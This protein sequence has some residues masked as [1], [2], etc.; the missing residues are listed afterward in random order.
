MTA[1][2]DIKRTES[3]CYDNVL[4]LKTIKIIAW[5][6]GWINDECQINASSETCDFHR[7]KRSQRYIAF[8]FNNDWAF[9]IVIWV[10]YYSTPN[11]GENSFSIFVN[12]TRY[13]WWMS[14]DTTAMRMI[15]DDINHL[16]VQSL[17][18]K[19]SADF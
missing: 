6:Y 2:Q 9:F 8:S 12:M 19:K 7:G 4:F 11:R 17:S 14:N 3:R 10:L 5:K 15:K 1:S 13:Q 16:A 18:S